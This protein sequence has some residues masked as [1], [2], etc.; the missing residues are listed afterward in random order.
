M[1]W[2]KGCTETLTQVSRSEVEVIVDLCVKILLEYTGIFYI[3]LT[4]MTPRECSGIGMCS[5]FEVGFFFRLKVIA[6]YSLSL[7]TIIVCGYKC[8]VYQDFKDLTK[9]KV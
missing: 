4:R 5:D 2:G 3:Y 6:I 7:F 8:T 1:P 9:L